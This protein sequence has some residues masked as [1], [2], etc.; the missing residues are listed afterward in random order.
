MDLTFEEARSVFD[1]MLDG[2][3]ERGGDR[4]MLILLA[5]KGETEHEIAAAAHDLRNRAIPLPH[6]FDRL[7]DTCG[8][9]G[10]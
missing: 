3:M 1:E 4:E 8:T 6:T 10:D 9:G 2:E 7:L 5:E